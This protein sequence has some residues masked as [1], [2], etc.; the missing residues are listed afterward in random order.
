MNTDL[1]PGQLVM[2]NRLA[3]VFAATLGVCCRTSAVWRLRRL[4]MRTT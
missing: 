2:V 1:L 4:M 3:T